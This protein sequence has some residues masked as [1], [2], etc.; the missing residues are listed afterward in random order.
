MNP[1]TFPPLRFKGVLPTIATAAGL[2]LGS[3]ALL[4]AGPSKAQLVDFKSCTFGVPGATCGAV[5]GPISIG[6]KTYSNFQ[7]I[8]TGVFPTAS[9]TVDLSWV[10]SNDGNF[11]NDE[12]VADLT[13]EPLLAGTQGPFSFSYDVAITLPPNPAVT[14]PFGGG[15][16]I[17]WDGRAY[18]FDTVSLESDSTTPT[19][20]VTKTITADGLILTVL[21]SVNG[22]PVP[23]GVKT[24][25]FTD[26]FTKVNIQDTFQLTGSTSTL[27]SISNSLT[28]RAVEVP[29]PL[30]ILGAGMA[31]GFSRKLRKRITARSMA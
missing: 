26:N 1:L 27:T 14:G 7:F 2:L 8:P 22:E 18:V 20:N 28:Q 16:P 30:P 13:W 3:G 31:F 5:S 9:G 11:A 4:S 6:D 19:S 15:A 29:G 25:T 24:Y 17:S 10:G 21:N 12:F 23:A